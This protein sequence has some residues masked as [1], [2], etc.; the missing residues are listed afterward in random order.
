MI[1]RYP[2]RFEW[3]LV[4]G[5]L[6]TEVVKGAGISALTGSQENKNEDKN[7]NVERM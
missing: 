4:T 1:S 5:F 3:P 6:P 7:E 2:G